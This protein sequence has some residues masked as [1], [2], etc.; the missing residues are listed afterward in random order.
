VPA[1][2]EDVIAALRRRKGNLPYDDLLDLMTSAGCRV[3]PTRDGCLMIHA[4]V[5]G[6]MASVAR[7]HGK[8]GGN[9]VLPPYVT[10]CIRLLELVLEE[11]ESQ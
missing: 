10:K 7:P 11:G 5:T 8:S 3:K 4:V 1:E 9:A 2:I 6:F